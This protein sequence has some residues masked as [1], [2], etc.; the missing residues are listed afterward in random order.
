MS[1]RRRN[2]RSE[3]KKTHPPRS[4]L[5]RPRESG[6]PLYDEIVRTIRGKYFREKARMG[7]MT[8]QDLHHET[9]LQIHR[10]VKRNPIQNLRGLIATVAKIVAL[11]KLRSK[12]VRAENGLEIVRNRRKFVTKETPLH[13]LERTEQVKR[14][15]ESIAKLRLSARNK[16]I[17]E[18][19]L[20]GQ[21]QGKSVQTIAKE[22]GHSVYTFESVIKRIR[23]AILK[24]YSKEH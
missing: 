15:L 20:Q 9:Y 19:Y 22:L 6:D 7:G 4:P 11:K 1:N 2:P 24:R 14:L 16:R 12:P 8:I 13:Q 23:A 5:V 3:R 17:F 10:Y 21:L 18:A